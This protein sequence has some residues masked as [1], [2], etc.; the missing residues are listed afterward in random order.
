MYCKLKQVAS[1]T[2]KYMVSYNVTSLFTNIPLE[3]TIH[4]TIDLLFQAKP[5]LKISR[6]GLQKLFQFATSQTNFLFNGSVYDQVDGVAMGS[7]LAP[8]LANIFMEYHKKGWI[9]NYNYGGL[10]CY[11]R[12]VDDIFAVFETKDHAVSFDNYINRTHT[13]IKF[14]METEKKR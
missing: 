2:N 1:V 9:R 6:K 10:L 8:I 3:E 7:P 11:K 14:I 13:N 12:Y 4:L 5:D